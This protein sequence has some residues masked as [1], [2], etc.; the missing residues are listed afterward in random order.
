MTVDLSKPMRGKVWK[1]GD[2]VD[3]DV[4]APSQ[5]A[6]TLEEV[7]KITMEAYRPEFAK[8]VKPGDIIVAG[9]NFGCGSQRPW[10]TGVLQAVGIQAVVAESV[11]RLFFRVGI[12]IGLP[13]FTAQG[14]SG[15]VEDGDL[16]EIDAVGG[17]VRNPRNGKSIPLDK[18]PPS[19][20][21][22]LR[23]GGITPLVV[24]RLKAEGRA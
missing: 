13:I 15:L 6:S 10:A 7:K 21:S 17:T 24:Q 2:S 9:G 12:S 19:I 1:F 14:V 3:T 22:I 18:Y 23:A 11:G 8:E 4:I 5:R 16:I 20:E